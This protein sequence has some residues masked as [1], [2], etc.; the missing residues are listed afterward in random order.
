[1]KLLLISLAF[2]AFPL[3]GVSGDACDTLVPTGLKTLLLSKFTGYRLPRESDNLPEDIKYAREHAGSGCLGVETADFDGDG[4][5]DYLVALTSENGAGALV[6]VAMSRGVTWMVHKLDVWKDNRPRLYVSSAPPGTYDD[7]GE[8]D[9]P[10]E[11]GAEEHLTCPH[12]LAVFGAT[13]STGVAYCFLNGKWKHV[14][15]SD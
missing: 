15:I 4:R 11:K 8:T 2:L 12:S 1:M 13:E 14:W 7:V 5:L 6:L 3:V 9:G 10:L